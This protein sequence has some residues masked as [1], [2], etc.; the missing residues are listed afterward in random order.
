MFIALGVIALMLFGAWLARAMGMPRVNVVSAFTV[1]WVTMLAIATVGGGVTDVIADFTWVIILTGWASLLV[2][3]I[4]GW[5]LSRSSVRQHAPLRI[6]I[7]RTF[8]FHLLFTALFAVYVVIQLVNA[9]PLIEQAGGFQVIL[10]SGAN[11][12]RAASLQQ[13]LGQSQDDLSGGALN[14]IINYATFIPGTIATYTGAILWKA[15]RRFIAMSP[16]LL[17]GLLGLLTMQR[18]SIVLVLLLFVI[19]IW[20][21]RLSGVEV[22]SAKQRT[23]RL[24]QTRAKPTGRFGA[25][26]AGLGLLAVIGVFLQV[27][28]QAR[29]TEAEGA[30]LQSAIGEYLIGGIAG[31]NS[32]SAQGPDWPAVP[33][34]V[35]GLFD[36][37]PG[38]GGYTF[39]GLWSVLSRLGVP[40]ETTRINLDF[41]QVNLFGEPTITNVV[42]AFGEFYL[43]FRL[44]G[45]VILS[46]LLGFFCS[47][48]QGRLQGSQRLALVPAVTFLL[49]YSFWSF[50]VAWSSDFR[51]LLVAMLG[52][53]I[54]TWA[55]RS[56]RPD[57]PDEKFRDASPRLRS[58]TTR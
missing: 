22:P 35:A 37:S 31:M 44:F 5:Q 42:S 36:P 32:R 21:L 6:D 16:L 7:R 34:D 48:M 27:T 2:G 23:S 18:T 33:S 29:S 24:D 45:V 20:T 1:S 55:V 19:G 28:T 38:M 9:L 54:L 8:R 14:S 56:R 26:V 53:L 3:A 11:S 13:A 30:T 47:L 58:A 39:T 40:V 12:Y 25:V 46:F 43:D 17:G 41:T 15:G 10:T 4:L 50:F 52:G 49:T 51:Q 57:A